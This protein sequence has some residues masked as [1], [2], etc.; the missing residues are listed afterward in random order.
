VVGIAI[1]I[2]SVL[3]RNYGWGF[4]GLYPE[5]L[6]IPPKIQKPAILGEKVVKN[7]FQRYKDIHRA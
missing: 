4:S 6:K 2:S 3:S 7:T 5:S 1:E